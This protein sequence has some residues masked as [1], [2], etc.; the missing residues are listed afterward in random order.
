MNIDI[1]P[2]TY[3]VAVSG[4][5]DSVA[6]LHALQN[7]PSLKLIVAHYDHGIRPDSS[8]DRHHVAA[9]ARYYGLPFIYDIGR[10]GKGS[11]EDNARR[12][13]YQFLHGVRAATGAKA[14]IT[15]HHQDDAVETAVLQ[16]LRGTGRRGLTSLGSKPELLRPL[17]HTPKSEII[18]YA[19]DQGLLW[20]EDSSNEDVR[21]LRNRVRHQILPKLTYE[22]RQQLHEL[23][24]TT[25]QINEEIDGLL[26]VALHL[27]PSHN[28]LSRRWFAGLPYAVAKEVMAHWLRRHNIRGFDKKQLEQ[29][30]VRSKT[31][32]SPLQI[33]VDKRH[34][35]EIH[36]DILVLIPRAVS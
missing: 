27:Q 20:H 18:N 8:A 24:R 30:V 12:A 6:L 16:L 7:R 3:V 23:I 28:S 36:K 34:I 22:Q 10:L 29:I 35:L 11:S 17:L 13:R 2:G 25:K 32:A 5:V 33:D 26:N 1:E 4:G 15:A 19:H 9:I 21:Y 14:I 31:L